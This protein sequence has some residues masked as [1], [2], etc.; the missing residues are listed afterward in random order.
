MRNYINNISEFKFI[1]YTL[2]AVIVLQFFT[3]F[4]L[5]S[6]VF[7]I[8]SLT[9]LCLICLFL[10]YSDTKKQDEIKAKITENESEI[11]EEE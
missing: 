4:F 9:T 7:I 8:F 2:A 6:Y 5:K 1:K 11:I 3:V 10:M